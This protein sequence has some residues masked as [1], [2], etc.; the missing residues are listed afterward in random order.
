[1][2]ERERDLFETVAGD[3]QFEG[4]GEEGESTSRGSK[5][6]SAMQSRER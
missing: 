4:R 6:T 2:R 5:F 3:S 1:M